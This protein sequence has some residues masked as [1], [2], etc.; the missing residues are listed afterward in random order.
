LATVSTEVLNK[1]CRFT[2]YF[3][4]PPI[5]APVTVATRT[6]VNYANNMYTFASWRNETSLSAPASCFRY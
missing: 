4:Q 5:A 3:Q 6:T 2:V 1:C